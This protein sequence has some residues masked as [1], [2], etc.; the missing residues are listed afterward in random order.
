MM[1]LW[2]LVAY[3]SS[4]RKVLTGG[5]GALEVS[6]AKRVDGVYCDCGR[7][8][9]MVVHPFRKGIGCFDVSAS[10]AT[11]SVRSLHD[12]HIQSYLRTTLGDV[13]W[14]RATEI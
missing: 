9:E 4:D 12:T 7:E 1:T 5:K 11:E 3:F 6:C 13:M 14:F 2:Q 8:V 10:E